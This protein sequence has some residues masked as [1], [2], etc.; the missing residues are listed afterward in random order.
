VLGSRE[1]ANHQKVNVGDSDH[2][3]GRICEQRGSLE[4][5]VVN[6][7]LQLMK[8]YLWELGGIKINSNISK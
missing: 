6:R 4:G 5:E 7:S 1:R 2:Q 8:T 3:G